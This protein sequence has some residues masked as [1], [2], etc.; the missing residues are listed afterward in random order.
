MTEE[1]HRRMPGEALLDDRGADPHRAPRAGAPR[2]GVL[3]LQGD[4]L[5]HLR[6]LS[7]VGAN[8]VAVHAP[9]DLDGLDGLVL[10][11][12][13]STTI[14]LLCDLH[15]LMEPLQKLVADGFPVLGTCA[16]AILL[17]GRA[18]RHDGEVS[19]QPLIGG[20]D[21]VVRRNAFGRQVESFEA[22]I[23]VAGL[24]APMLAVFIRAPW[25]ESVGP[26][27]ETLA[28]VE[29]KLGAKVVVARQGNLLAS[30]FHPELSGEDRLHELFVK[31]LL[32]RRV[33]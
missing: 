30:A 17:A 12:G 28:S 23:D 33:L 7:R 16:G 25:F 8:G 9:G 21:T 32:P 24:D 6:I 27:V 26:G 31:T 22:E 5:E 10:P 1:I 11:G 14:G 15:G 19:P 29:T 20:M 13:E 3:A 2:V 18:L 4:V